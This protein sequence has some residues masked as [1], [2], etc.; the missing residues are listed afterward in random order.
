MFFFAAYNTILKIHLAMVGAVQVPWEQTTCVR[1]EEEEATA[2]QLMVVV[3]LLLTKMMKMMKM[4]KIVVVV[5]LACWVCALM[6]QL[7]IEE[8]EAGVRA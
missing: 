1:Q 6:L 7:M 2:F 8:E 5:A 4:M 3:L